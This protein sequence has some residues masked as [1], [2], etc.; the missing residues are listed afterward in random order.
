MMPYVQH[1]M[2]RPQA[3]V[4]DR[5]AAL[6]F[7]ALITAFAEKGLLPRIPGSGSALQIRGDGTTRRIGG[8]DYTSAI[9]HA[10][11]HPKPLPIFCESLMGEEVDGNILGQRIKGM[12]NQLRVLQTL[13]ERSM[14]L[15]VSTTS[16]TG[17]LS[18]PIKL[19]ETDTNGPSRNVAAGAQMSASRDHF[20]D[21]CSTRRPGG[22]VETVSLRCAPSVPFHHTGLGGR[23]EGAKLIIEQALSSTPGTRVLTLLGSQATGLANTEYDLTV[24]YLA[25]KDARSTRVI[26]A[27]Q[28]VSRLCRRPQGPPPPNQQSPVPPIVFSLGGMRNGSTTKIFATWK[29]NSVDQTDALCT[30]VTGTQRRDDIRIIG[31]ASSGLSSEDIDIT[32]VSLASQ[33]SQTATL[34]LATT[35]DDSAAEELP[36]SSRNTSM[37]WH[38]KNDADVVGY[39]PARYASGSTTTRATL[40]L[41]ASHSSTNMP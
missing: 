7:L 30:F 17:G 25:S 12:T 26:H 33:D 6:A 39:E 37:P 40:M 11:S 28:Q 5:N 9:R 16:R 20:K 29:R 3:E 36:N 1:L 34:P 41:T 31:S 2:E 21:E 22:V 10:A 23:H 24:V 35:E 4:V 38:G 19:L 18:L 15:F 8:P 14:T 27:G 13:D 32:I